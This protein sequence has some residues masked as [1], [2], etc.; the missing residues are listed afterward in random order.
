MSGEI[1]LG[2]PKERIAERFFVKLTNM[3]SGWRFG[4]AP[5]SS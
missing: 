3:A 1:S 5:G 2:F 4:S